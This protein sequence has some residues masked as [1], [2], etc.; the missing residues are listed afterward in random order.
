MITLAKNGY[1][2][3]TSESSLEEFSKQWNEIPKGTPIYSLKA[4]SE[5]ADKQGTFLG[6]IVVDGCTTS[7]FGDERLFF[8]HQRIEEDIA[9]KPDWKAAYMTDC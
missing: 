6:N 8:Q 7:K 9:L 1:N 4:H 5:P 2:F 3:K